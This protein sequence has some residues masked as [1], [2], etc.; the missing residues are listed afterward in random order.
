MPLSRRQL[1]TA[2]LAAAAAAPLAGCYSGASAD[3]DV[4][5]IWH[6]EDDASAMGRAWAKAVE[7]FKAENPGIRVNLVRQVFASSKVSAKVILSSNDVPDVMEYNKGSADAGLLS[8]IG[9][10]TPLTE[11]VGRFGWDKV[12][13]TPSLQ[14]LSKY[15]ADGVAGAGDWY[16][17]PN[18]GEYILWYYN[19]DF[20]AKHRLQVPGSPAEL[21]T[22]LARVKKLGV[23]PVAS[24]AKEFPFM[25]TW[26]QYILRDAPPDW[27]DH[28]QLLKAPVDFGAAYWRNG[29]A[30]AQS[31]VADGYTSPN[32]TGITHEEMGV[33]FI[34]GHSPLMTSGSW[35]YG[36]LAAEAKFDWG[37]FPWPQQSLTQGSV[38]NL[39]VV[40]TNARNKEL[41]YKFIDVTLRPEVQNVFYELGGLP[42]AGT[43]TKNVDERTREFTETF[44]R[45]ARE[46][47]L[48]FY[49]DFPMPG[50][51]DELLKDSQ[52]LANRSRTPDDLIGSLAAFYDGQRA[53]IKAAR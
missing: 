53:K 34:G 10:L 24:A 30:E 26:F 11:P 17:I 48:A 38:G 6:Y 43:P 47:R 36:R 33:N 16:G 1:L 46:S 4:L 28:W 51:L 29:T 25:Q 42:L 37:V 32:I 2:G 13:S 39:W 9:L 8:S 21:S 35:W 41:A 22:L 18:Y 31:L 14:Q 52:S 12:L 3:P 7:V 19:K 49:P 45:Y 23:V 50:L 27:V 15:D 40:P 44:Q 5:T 20:F